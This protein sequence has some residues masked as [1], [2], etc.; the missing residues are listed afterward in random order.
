[1]QTTVKEKTAP[2]TVTS[3]GEGP[4]QFPLYDP[5]TTMNLL[6]Q[7]PCPSRCLCRQTAEERRQTFEIRFH[8]LAFYPT[9]EGSAIPRVD[10]DESNFSADRT[11]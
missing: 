8:H 5:N 10:W 11:V 2:N 3:S 9:Q 4:L 6:A 1:M 7:S